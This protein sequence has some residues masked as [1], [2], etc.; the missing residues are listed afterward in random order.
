ME[1]EAEPEHL[2]EKMQD[3]DLMG[4]CQILQL[5]HLSNCRAC[6]QEK[7]LIRLK[8]EAKKEGGFYV[9]PE[10]KLAFVIRIRGINDMHP[11]TK[12]ILQLLRLR[13]IF[14]GVFVKVCPSS[15]RAGQ[16]PSLDLVG[17]DFC[18]FHGGPARYKLPS[19]CSMSC[20]QRPVELHTAAVSLQ[21]AFWQARVTARQLPVVIADVERW[22]ADQQ[23]HRQHA[24]AGGA[25]RGLGLPQPEDRARADL[26]ARLRQGMPLVPCGTRGVTG[27]GCASLPTPVWA[28]LHCIESVTCWHCTG[29]LADWVRA[30]QVIKDR[31]PLTDNTIIEKVQPWLIYVF[32]GFTTRTKC[33]QCKLSWCLETDV[34]IRTCQ[35]PGCLRA[36]TGKPSTCCHANHVWCPQ[37][38]G[39][40]NIICMEDLVHEV[41]TVGPNFKQVRPRPSPSDTQRPVLVYATML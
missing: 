7:D 29:S 9:E 31:I 36:L 33:V 30:V 2:Q 15:M 10:A 41:Y 5:V 13:Q 19:G 21:A 24:T 14:N 22:P 37:V 32:A 26:Q 8:R 23:G 38:L 27:A 25:L 40:Y 34:L 11:K 12:K 17:S 20:S 39:K 1:P 16:I 4:T 35:T 6:L 3:A 28:D 18:C